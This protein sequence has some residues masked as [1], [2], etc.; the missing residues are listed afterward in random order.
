[1]TEPRNAVQKEIDKRGEEIEKLTSALEER[2][3]I[4]A[5]WEATVER[6]DRLI[7]RQ[8]ETDKELRL[9]ISEQDK[10]IENLNETLDGAALTIAWCH[11]QMEEK[12]REIAQLKAKGWKEL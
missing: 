12:D 6:N 8:S 2:D 9:A 11:G 5:R 3:K 10:A 1:M 4:I 7:Y